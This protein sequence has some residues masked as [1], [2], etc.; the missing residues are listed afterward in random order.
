MSTVS[1]WSMRQSLNMN[2]YRRQQKRWMKPI[3]SVLSSIAKTPTSLLMRLEK[4]YSKV[5]FSS[6]IPK[7]YSKNWNKS[8]KKK[9]HVKHLKF[10]WNILRAKQ[11][12]RRQ[13]SKT[14]NPTVKIIMISC[15]KGQLN[16]LYLYLRKS[17]HLINKWI[18]KLGWNSCRRPNSKKR[19]SFYSKWWRK[20]VQKWWLSGKARCP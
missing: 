13:S 16:F 19:K 1:N 7:K 12:I 4:N 8:V 3:L 20:E 18:L 9:K 15:L 17:L 6:L 2:H 10:K 5:S 14:L 11:V